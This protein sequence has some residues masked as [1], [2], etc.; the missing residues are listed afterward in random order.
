MKL[1]T[2][3]YGNP[4]Y[5]DCTEQSPFAS[6]VF[7]EHKMCE[8]D[9][10]HSV[11]TNLGRITV[12]DRMTGFD[13]GRD[14]ETGYRAPDGK[15]WLASGHCDVRTSGVATLG[16]AIAWIKAHANNCKGED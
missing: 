1:I 7:T 6:F 10:L 5:E 13:G 11:H 14:I 8:D 12:L 4:A 16:E 3:K 15:F 2:N 9:M